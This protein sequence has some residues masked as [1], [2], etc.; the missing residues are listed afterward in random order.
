MSKFLGSVVSGTFLAVVWLALI[1]TMMTL[2]TGPWGPDQAISAEPAPPEGQKYTGA[3][4]CASCHFKQFLSWSKTKHAKSFELL[5]KK[6]QSDKEC[7][8]CHTTGYGQPSGFKD[9]KKSSALK[10][11]GCETCHGPGSKHAEISKGFGKEKLSK[12]QEK[13]VRDS[14]WMMLPKNVCVE[15]HQTQA[16]GKTGTPKELQKK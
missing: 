9:A 2:G 5:P 15:C 4:E 7:L 3:K 1:A 14:I 12:E 10:G 6:Y 13:E 16:H 8:G 11:T